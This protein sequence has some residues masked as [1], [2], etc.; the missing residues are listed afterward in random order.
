MFSDR[1]WEKQV[2]RKQKLRELRADRASF[3]SV[4]ADSAQV[5]VWLIKRTMLDYMAW[6]TRKNL[7]ARAR[8]LAD[9]D[10]P[11]NIKNFERQKVNMQ[12]WESF[13]EKLALNIMRTKKAH[14]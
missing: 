13:K 6:S 9:E 12:N 10:R 1:Q 3:L 11:E 2:K 7:I 5:Q 8:H 14:H 4:V